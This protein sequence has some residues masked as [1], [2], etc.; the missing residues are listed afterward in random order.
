MKKFTTGMVFL[1]L[2]A[3]GGLIALG[4]YLYLDNQKIIKTNGIFNDK[5]LILKHGIYRNEIEFS[6]GSIVAK[7]VNGSCTK[8]DKLEVLDVKNEILDNK[9]ILDA[10]TSVYGVFKRDTPL[11]AWYVN[12]NLV[13]EKDSA[14]FTTVYFSDLDLCESFGTQKERFKNLYL[15]VKQDQKDRI[16]K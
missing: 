13:K 16:G 8:I 15:E 7:F 4:F 12:K 2:I 9:K 3:L 5:S 1:S 11:W 6:E 10:V 14:D